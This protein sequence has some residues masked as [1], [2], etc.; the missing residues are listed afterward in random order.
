MEF[1]LH[2]YTFNHEGTSLIQTSWPSGAT[3]RRLLQA[4]PLNLDDAK[5]IAGL[6]IRQYE[7]QPDLYHVP[8]SERRNT[9]PATFFDLSIQQQF[10]KAP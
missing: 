7:A 6:Y 10:Q 3:C 8:T 4:N 1:S 2:S 5:R 9:R